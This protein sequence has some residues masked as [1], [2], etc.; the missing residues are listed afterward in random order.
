[1]FFKPTCGLKATAP[2][3]YLAPGWG[4]WRTRLSPNRT[5]ATS[6][7]RPLAESPKLLKQRLRCPSPRQTAAYR[8]GKSAQGVRWCFSLIHAWYYVG[9]YAAVASRQ[10]LVGI[11]ITCQLKVPVLTIFEQ[12][13]C[14]CEME[15]PHVV[16]FS[17]KLAVPRTFH[18]TF[19]FHDM[20]SLAE[21]HF[22]QICTQA[23]A[24]SFALSD[25]LNAHN[26][27]IRLVGTSEKSTANA[28]CL[29]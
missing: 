1:V 28:L 25:R 20:V 3:L 24:G 4:L 5:T 6:A 19:H 9:R 14:F 13:V 11:R 29:V 16:M 12:L 15:R 26:G 7:A 22:V 18:R 27:S 21:N 17:R 2:C 10:Q 8:T 23:R